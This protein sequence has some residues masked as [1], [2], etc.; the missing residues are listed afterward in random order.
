VN[1]GYREIIEAMGE[2]KWWNEHAAPR[3]VEFNPRE[4]A[5]IY[6][7]EVVLALIVCQDCGREFRVCFSRDAVSAVMRERSLASLSQAHELHYGDPPNIGCCPAGPTM[8]SVPMR[9]LE[10]WHR[11]ADTNHEWKRRA[12]HEI[13]IT[14]DWAA[15]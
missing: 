2:P 12:Q 1:Q 14:P 6:A 3:Y 5:N 10:Y 11:G 7:C 15:R 4:A 9:V 8:N 13:E